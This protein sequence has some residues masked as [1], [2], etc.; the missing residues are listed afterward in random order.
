MLAG[1]DRCLQ[2]RAEG[3]QMTPPR[4]ENFRTFPA[5]KGYV[6]KGRGFPEEYT[7]SDWPIPLTR[8]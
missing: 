3:L 8:E 4:R 6:E 7:D 5:T 2:F 1:R